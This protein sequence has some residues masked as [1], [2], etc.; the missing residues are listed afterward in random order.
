MGSR[1][2]RSAGVASKAGLL[3]VSGGVIG[4]RFECEGEQLVREILLQ[5]QVVLVCGI[6]VIGRI[7]VVVLGVG[8]SAANGSGAGRLVG[9]LGCC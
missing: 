7:R 1:L 4:V 2:E 5:L 8:H 6:V 3:R 9:G